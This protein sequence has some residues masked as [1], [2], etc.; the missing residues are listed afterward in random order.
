[1]FNL[2]FINF[3]IITLTSCCFFYKKNSNNSSS[4]NNIQ[5]EDI[6]VSFE[7]F[8]DREKNIKYPEIDENLK[9]DFLNLFY[10]DKFKHNV[11]LLHGKKITVEKLEKQIQDF[12]WL[13]KAKII[14]NKL[15]KIMAEK[16]ILS[17]I[18][19]KTFYTFIDK[20]SETKTNDLHKEFLFD[21]D[22]QILRKL[23]D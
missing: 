14:K 20:M 15:N 5:D 23:Y 22:K 9:N 10:Y 1:M 4:S 7:S 19:Y 18:K 6:V 21:V 13:E 11:I 2:I 16:D 12:V 17:Y 8:A 3:I